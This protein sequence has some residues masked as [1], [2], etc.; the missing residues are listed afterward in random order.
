VDTACSSALVALHRAARAVATGECE[1]ALAGGVSLM[2]SVESLV[3]T[4]RLGI[5]S[6]D[7]VCRAFDA[8]GKGYV[9]GEGVGCVL[10]KPL[11]RALADGDPVHAVIL[12]SAENH[13]GRAQSLT[14]PNALAQA[15]VIE[16]ALRRAGV[17]SDTIGWIEAHGTGTE[18]GDPV[19]ALALR[20]AFARTAGDAAERPRCRIGALKPALG[21]LEPASGI[22]GLLKVVLAMRHRMQPAT[23]HFRRL[24]PHVDLAGSP[25]DMD[26]RMAPWAPMRRRGDGAMLPRRAGVSA[27]GFGGS[28]AHV[29]LEEP[30]HLPPPAPASDPLLLLVSARDRARL[31]ETL[32]LLA[33]HVREAGATLDLQA[34]ADTLMLGREPLPARAA[35]LLRS[36][37]DAAGRLEAAAIAL[38]DGASRRRAAGPRRGGDAGGALG[39]GPTR[40]PCRAVGAG[41]RGG[42]GEAAAPGTTPHL[43]AGSAVRAR[44]MLVRPS[45][46]GRGG[47]AG[48]GR[49]GAPR[50]GGGGTRTAGGRRAARGRA[51]HR[52][53]S[54]GHARRCD[55]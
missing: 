18:L 28:N 36:G 15:A 14:A 53:D 39:A 46:G 11:S 4:Q 51:L 26:G 31:A 22:A 9:K 50:G 7:G 40:L 20:E 34:V 49:S 27:F 48:C 35:I 19:E 2:L 13:G 6:P 1:M 12:G 24:S 44:P 21:H 41:W 8:E 32:G 5:L 37:Q 47:H 30:P 42:L 33:R 25:L 16:A 17:T 45:G 3:S 38:A 43:P 55:A 54:A 52:A 29:V 23:L 10:L